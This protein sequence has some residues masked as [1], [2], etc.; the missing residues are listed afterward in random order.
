MTP[1]V[2][3]LPLDRSTSMTVAAAHSLLSVEPAPELPDVYSPKLTLDV[4]SGPGLGYWAVTSA[5]R[6]LPTGGTSPVSASARVW[7][8]PSIPSVG[9]P[10]NV[11]AFDP[12]VNQARAA[13]MAHDLVL[14]LMIESEARRAHDL[15]LAADGASGDGLTEFTDVITQDVGGGKV[16]QKGYSLDPVDLDLFLPKFSTQARR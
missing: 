9:V 5:G 10:S 4:G 1:A 13:Q 15:I 16:I 14:D 6:A 2:R 8:L 11:V 12:S 7:I 3:W